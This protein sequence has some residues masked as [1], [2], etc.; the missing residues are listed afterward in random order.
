MVN[1][2]HYFTLH[3][4]VKFL[5]PI[6]TQKFLTEYIKNK[7]HRIKITRMFNLH[8]GFFYT[9]ISHFFTPLFFIVSIK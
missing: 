8:R 4:S 5:E 6:L 2:H 7:L 9:V 1:L 3:R